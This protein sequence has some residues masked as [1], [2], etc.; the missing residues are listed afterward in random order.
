VSVTARTSV[1]GPEQCFVLLVDEVPVAT[2]SFVHPD[3]P[4]RPNL[5]PWLAG[6]Y[7]QPEFRCRGFASHSVRPGGKNSDYMAVY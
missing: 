1:S 2:A 6:V 5:T 3:L 4:S 7:V